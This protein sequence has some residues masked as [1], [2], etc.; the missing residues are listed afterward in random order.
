MP[1][2]GIWLCPLAATVGLRTDIPL[3]PILRRGALTV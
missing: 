2:P 3:R 1:I